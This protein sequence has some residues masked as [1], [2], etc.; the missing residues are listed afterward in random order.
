MNLI[1][2]LWAIV[3][4]RLKK[5][6]ITTKEELIKIWHPEQEIKNTCPY[7]VESIPK[8]VEL[9]LKA[10]GMYTSINV[11]VTCLINYF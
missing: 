3:K 1:D 11:A 9:L 7:L 10:K 4:K 2:N 5:T 6:S 8:R